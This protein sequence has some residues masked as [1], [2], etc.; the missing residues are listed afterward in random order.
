MSFKGKKILFISPR[1]FNYE[2]AIVE[3]LTELGAKVEF[4]D[5]RPS[6]SIFS[7]GIIRVNPKLYKSQINKYYQSIQNKIKGNTYD[8]FLLIKGESIPFEFLEELHS[9]QPKAKKIFYTYDSVHE[10]PKFKD[11]M[12]Y[13]DKN[14]SFEPSDV[15]E[16]SFLFRP[17]FYLNTYQRNENYD[18]KFDIVFIG[19]AHTD[20]YIIG[21]KVNQIAKDLK[22][23]TYFY[24][25]IP[26][27]LTY[28]FKKI[29]DQNF[30]RF[31]LDK[32]SFDK[33]THE[34]ISDIYSNSFAVLD[35]NKPFQL[36]LS[37]RTFDTLAS[38]KKL[39]TT[40]HEIKKY[41]IYNPNN[42]LV[43]DRENVEIDL[44]FFKNEFEAYDKNAIYKMSLESWLEDV[45]INDR[46][47]Y[48][49]NVIES[50][51]DQ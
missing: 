12:N 21:E 38:S 41:P 14:I 23:K 30:K 19:S 33:L 36:G 51:L 6:N 46:I 2:V 35:I 3:K 1:F 26:S 24:Y 32:L 13:F 9:N 39:I 34:Q 42:I 22:L 18:R 4:F 5:E 27:K 45:F 40:N 50:I 29:F 47:E 16:Y 10:Y 25:Y 15:K 20:R 11:L 8:Y 49:D 7:K 17:L 37:M 48:W 31:D 28:Y 44:D 43:I